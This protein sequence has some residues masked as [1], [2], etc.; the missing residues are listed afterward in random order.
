VRIGLSSFVLFELV[1]GVEVPVAIVK[2]GEVVVGG[3]SKFAFA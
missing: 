2:V 1:L 3:V